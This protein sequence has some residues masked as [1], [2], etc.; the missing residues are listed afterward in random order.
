[1]P[2]RQFSPCNAGAIHR[3]HRTS[4]TA[5][6]T[7]DLSAAFDLEFRPDRPNVFGAQRDYLPSV[8]TLCFSS[9]FIFLTAGSRLTSPVVW[10]VVA[11]GLALGMEVCPGGVCAGLVA[12]V[13]GAELDW[14]STGWMFK[15][16]KAPDSTNA[17]SAKGVIEGFVFIDLLLS[18]Q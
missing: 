3:R 16:R 2:L 11:G 15:R 14:A 18:D 17:A 13:L 9:S 8:S 5:L 1:M 10:V 12:V 4:P 6:G 7:V